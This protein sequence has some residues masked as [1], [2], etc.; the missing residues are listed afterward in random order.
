MYFEVYV[1]VWY[2]EEF[3]ECKVNGYVVEDMVSDVYS[4][5]VEFMKV[6]DEMLFDYASS[7]VKSLYVKS[8]RE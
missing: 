3:V 4:C 8:L 7:S 2:E 6:V 5:V 1:K